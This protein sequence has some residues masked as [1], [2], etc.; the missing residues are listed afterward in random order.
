ME[1]FNSMHYN[2]RKK[3]TAA[4]LNSTV[5]KWKVPIIIK[6][7]DLILAPFDYVLSRSIR[8]N[9]KLNLKGNIIIFDEAHNLET[10]TEQCFSPNIKISD[11]E[12]VKNRS[13]N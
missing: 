12:F 13:M 8:N 9:V 1:T 10:K 11:L 5:E 3:F 7:A 4:H 2:Y 6:D